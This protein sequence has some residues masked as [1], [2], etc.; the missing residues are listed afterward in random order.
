MNDPIVDRRRYELDALRAFAM[1][2]GV[3]LHAALA[4]V[5]DIWLVEDFTASLEGPWDELFLAIHG[6]RMP[7]FFLLSGFFTT[8]LWR[9]RGLRT[10]SLHRIQ[11]IVI[12]LAIGLIT[13]IPAMYLVTHWA[14]SGNIISAVHSGN[15][16]AVERLLDNLE[17][18]ISVE[19]R[20]SPGGW[21]LLHHA[22][23]AGQ[24]EVSALLLAR[25]ADPGSVAWAAENQETPF[26]LASLFGHGEVAELLVDYGQPNKLSKGSEW[27][28]L[29]GWGDGDR[30]RPR[31]GGLSWI[32]FHHLW[33]LW[34]LIWLISGFVI[35]TFF[36]E[37]IRSQSAIDG[38]KAWLRWVMWLL[39]PLTFLPQSAMS[40]GGEIPSF[41][42]DTS[43]GLIPSIHVL[44]YYLLF[45]TFGVLLFLRRDFRGVNLV[46]TL[47]RYWLILLPVTIILVLPAGLVVSFV[48]EL[49]SSKVG[50][51]W[52]LKNSL[53]V[54]Y[55]WGMCIGLI[56][57]FR[58]IFNREQRVVRYLA[59]ASYWIYLIHLPLVIFMQLIMR[60][61]KLPSGGKFFFTFFGITALLLLI[62]QLGIRYT[63]IGTLLNGK[64]FRTSSRTV[65]DSIN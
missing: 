18:D 62:Y 30:K 8:M 44:I 45:F 13:I 5:P 22:A 58:A 48:P 7:V 12:P 47:G 38:S 1:L 43:I 57:F 6:F 11:R 55:A 29:P 23:Y 24:A 2:L 16:G 10:L 46:D 56:G 33:F 32:S 21:S 17:H 42:P 4:Y 60:D 19:Y 27:S 20:D 61:W 59:D 26:G 39:I 63:P 15:V 34:M 50:F 54:L 52:F 3:G 65:E 14:Q 25:G 41:G 31:S 51:W 40:N 53:Q 36:I 64:K 35:I 9:Q 49:S 28:D 37:K